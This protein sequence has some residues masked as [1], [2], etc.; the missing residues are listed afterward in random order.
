METN[1]SFVYKDVKMNFSDL[2]VI[3]KIAVVLATVTGIVTVVMAALISVFII[4][5][6]LLMMINGGYVW[7]IVFA[8]A[9]V[10]AWYRVFTMHERYPT[11]NE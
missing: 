3:D 10:I 1:D 6:L 9:G 7:L 5:G 8:I 2:K 4:G 11:S